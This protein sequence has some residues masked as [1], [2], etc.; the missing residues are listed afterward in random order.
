MNK[1]ELKTKMRKVLNDTVAFYS[2][3]TNR[4]ATSRGGCLYYD[5]DH[6]N[7]CA[8]GRLLNDTDMKFLKATEQ[9]SNTSIDDIFDD[10]TTKKLK[11]LPMNFLM[12][13][14]GFHDEDDNWDEKGITLQGKDIINQIKHSI[15]TEYLK[16]Q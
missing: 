1:R 14:Q 5:K 13:L 2:K 6:N 9:L 15:N 12:D 7:K 11:E 8:I 16:T 4:R 3:N 10:L